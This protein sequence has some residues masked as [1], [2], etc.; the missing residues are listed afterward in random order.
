LITEYRWKRHFWS[1]VADFSEAVFSEDCEMGR[2]S[3]QISCGAFRVNGMKEGTAMTTKSIKPA[4][5]GQKYQI[6]SIVGAL[7]RD[8][9][10][11]IG[12]DREAAQR[13]I[14]DAGT[15]R[16]ALRAPL[17]EVLRD[18]TV[19]NQFIG[20]EVKS[21][22]LY[23]SGYKGARPI[24]EQTNRL[25]QIFPGIGS[26]DENLAKDPLPGGMEGYFAIPRWQSIASTYC[27]AVKIVLSKILETR[28]FKNA[29]NGPI[30]ASSFRQRRRSVAFWK[31]L[32]EQQSDKS[33]LVVPAQFGLRHRGRSTRRTLEVLQLNEFGLGVFATGIM[34]LTHP[35]RIAA[36]DDFCV[37]CVGD[38]CSPAFVDLFSGTMCWMF[39]QGELNLI[40]DDNSHAGSDTGPAT[41]VLPD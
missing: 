15:F 28:P 27:E 10:S 35:E 32:G 20:E 39:S 23:P 40:E 4:T 41:A 13:L 19:S 30:T 9:L 2:P 24:N 7:T 18:F 37:Y 6:A 8:V 17:T 1:Q 21:D 14:A 29:I 3:T 25:R 26:A 36:N 12:S 11:K 33:I 5:D 22:H 31:R 34:L 38:E 16:A